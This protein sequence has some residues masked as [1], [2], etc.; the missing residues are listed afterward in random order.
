MKLRT[1]WWKLESARSKIEQIAN[2]IA[3]GSTTA[4]TI[5]SAAVAQKAKAKEQKSFILGSPLGEGPSATTSKELEDAIYGMKAGEATKTP[6]KIGD[7]YYI[8]GVTN[9]EEANMEDFAKQRDTL[10]EQMLTRKRGEVFQD[11]IGAV[12]L[13]YEK[14]GNIK[15]YKEAVA[16][17]DAQDGGAAGLP[18]DLGG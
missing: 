5:A 1:S 15:I 11:Y 16:K 2:Q 3:A 6:I 10:M 18:F 13:R 14:D 8:V 17:V 12:R 4:A 9:R 7:A